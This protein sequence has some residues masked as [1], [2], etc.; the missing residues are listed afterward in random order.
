VGQCIGLSNRVLLDSEIQGQGPAR[1]GAPEID[2]HPNNMNRV[3]ALLEQVTKPLVH[4]L[5]DWKK[6][7]LTK[8]KI[9][10]FS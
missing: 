1:A 4:L 7:A 10:T 2:L 6:K 8:D 3:G 5:K 9:G